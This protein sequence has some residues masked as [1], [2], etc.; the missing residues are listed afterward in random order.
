MTTAFQ[1]GRQIPKC[2]SWGGGGGK[3]CYIECTVLT[4]SPYT[5]REHNAYV[6]SAPGI[7]LEKPNKK[8]FTLNRK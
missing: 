4:Q 5:E 2:V 8:H 1:E 7:I 3:R 6:M